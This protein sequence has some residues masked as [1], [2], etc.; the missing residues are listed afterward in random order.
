MYSPDCTT[1]VYCCFSSSL[2]PTTQ[3]D[4]KT[5]SDLNLKKIH[6]SK[7][8]SPPTTIRLCTS[9]R[10]SMT[11]VSN[12]H[13]PPQ[14]IIYCCE[15]DE[16]LRHWLLW[17]SVRKQSISASL[18]ELLEENYKIHLTAKTLWG[19]FCQDKC[20]CSCLDKPTTYLFKLCVLLN[21]D[22]IVQ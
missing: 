22:F 3:K 9:L 1:D 20:R 11:A 19:S 15:S 14:H 21:R 12:R 2:K 16:M 4:G 18:K 6:H 17:M 7:T 13:A 10:T 5:G 8:A